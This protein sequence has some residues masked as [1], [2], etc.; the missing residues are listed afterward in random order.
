MKSRLNLSVII[1]LSTALL[2]SHGVGVHGAGPATAAATRPLDLYRYLRRQPGGVFRPNS[3]G[4]FC[5]CNC[6]TEG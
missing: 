6:D 3:L 4:G 1:V 5:R 2:I